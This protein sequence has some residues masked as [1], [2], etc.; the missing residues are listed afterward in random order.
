MGCT[1]VACVS[2]GVEY[3]VGFVWLLLIPYA[4]VGAFSLFVPCK[5]SNSAATGA[6]N[7]RIV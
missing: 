7:H 6:S 1:R 2:T 5:P 3:W 4:Y